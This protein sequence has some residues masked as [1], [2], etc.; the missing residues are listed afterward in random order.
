MVVTPTERHLTELVGPLGLLTVDPGKAERLAE[1]LAGTF[2]PMSVTEVEREMSLSRADVAAIVAMGPSSRHVDEATLAAVIASL[3]DPA[4]VTL[5]VLV[6][7]YR[8]VT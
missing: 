2:L 4:I 5:S 3:P 6:S 7:E 8:R 1:S